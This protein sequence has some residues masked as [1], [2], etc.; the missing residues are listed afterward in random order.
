MSNKKSNEKNTQIANEPLVSYGKR[1]VFYNSFEEENEAQIAYWRSL[2]PAERMEQF[3]KTM[4][5]FFE[6]KAPNWKGMK[7]IFGE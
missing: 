3:T 6:H 5:G 7:I 1:I 4:A 2:S